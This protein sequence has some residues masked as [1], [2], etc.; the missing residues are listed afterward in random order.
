[1]FCTAGLHKESDMPKF[2]VTVVDTVAYTQEIEAYD[3]EAARVWAQESVKRGE[4]DTFEF[5]GV[6]E[7]HVNVDEAQ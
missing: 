1:M 2:L 3:E 6:I 5:V 4:L 7:R